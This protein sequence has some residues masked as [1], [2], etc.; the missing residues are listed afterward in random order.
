[1]LVCY[2]VRRGDL[3]RRWFWKVSFWLPRTRSVL[4]EARLVGVD[5]VTMGIFRI[6]EF[7]SKGT[8]KF[9]V[10]S[11]DAMP[12]PCGFVLVCM[13]IVPEFSSWFAI[14]AAATRLFA[15]TG[16][17]TWLPLFL[18]SCKIELRFVPFTETSS[19]CWPKVWAI[20]LSC[21]WSSDDASACCRSTCL[22]FSMSS[23]L[24]FDLTSLNMP[25][26]SSL[27]PLSV[28]RPL[29]I[30]PCSFILVC[31]LIELLKCDWD[32]KFYSNPE[33]C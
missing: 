20:A 6:P 3:L 4:W 2:S 23:M 30:C 31:V 16:L 11:A 28:R 1:M 5:W 25:S 21:L 24:S 18:I 9:D 33:T 27:Y 32:A 14:A 26:T 10:I 29:V 22:W 8:A 17:I 12:E 19:D 7:C 15:C 13:C